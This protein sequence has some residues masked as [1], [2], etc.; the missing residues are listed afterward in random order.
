[1]MSL[2]MVLGRFE[3]AMS[4]DLAISLTKSAD[5]TTRV[6]TQ[7]NCK[8][9]RAPIL[10]RERSK[11]AVQVCPSWWRFPMTSNLGG[12]GGKLGLLPLDLLRWNKRRINR[13]KKE[14]MTKG[15]NKSSSTLDKCI[16]DTRLASLKF[17]IF[18]SFIM[19]LITKDKPYFVWFATRFAVKVFKKKN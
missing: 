16:L 12:D 1:M 15:C 9:I 17:Q 8:S 3:K 7:P 19:H 13:R 18:H 2:A 4:C 11:G 6:G 14:T 10:V 5:E